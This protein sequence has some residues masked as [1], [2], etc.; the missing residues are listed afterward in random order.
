VNYIQKI[1]TILT[2][3]N[4]KDFSF[5]IFLSIIRTFI[6]VIGIGMLIPMFAFIT[7]NSDTKSKIF[8]YLS[9][10]EN[11]KDGQIILLFIFSFLFVY[12][13]KTMFVVFFN[14]Y[15][16]KFGEGL[17]VEISEKL[18]KKYLTKK[19]I[20]FVETNSANL[21]RNIASDTNGFAVGTVT[22]C[23]GIFSN[24]I[25][26]LGI[27]FL[28]IFYNFHSI[29]IIIAL[30]AICSLVANFNKK[31]FS[32]WAKIRHRESAKMIRKLNEGFGSIKEII[33]YKKSDY[34][35]DQ[36]KKPLINFS[37]AAVYKNAAA[38]I[39]APAI[40][41]AAVSIIFFF[42]VYLKFFTQIEFSEIITLFSILSFSAIK[43]LPNLT[44]ILKSFQTLKFNLPAVELIY[45][46]LI[47][48]KTNIIGNN[49]YI[50]DI[51]SIV[52]DK[53]NFR[54]PNTSLIALKN[55]NLQINSGDKIGIV[56]DTGSGKTTLINLIS[57]L[58]RPSS[59]NIL[60]NSK[61]IIDSKEYPL[62]VGYV[63]QSVY[64]SDDSILANISLSKKISKQQKI[65][66]K[67][68]LKILNLNNLNY[69]L[70]ERGSKLSGGQ[71]QRIGIARALY[72][73]PPLLIL[74]EA[75]NALDQKTEKKV[76]DFI[77]KEFNNKTVIFCTH[78]KKLL[79]Y[80]NKI[81][82]VKDAQ[83]SIIKN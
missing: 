9:F 79:K 63:S 80:C 78:K 73:E 72:R 51:S 17:Y 33:L 20:F 36:V 25:L 4:K 37:H 82:K 77:F 14:V 31:K 34:F 28:L 81:I 39:T 43:L 16:S 75:T 64:L 40:E 45:N 6:E 11:F 18:L 62:N 76:L 83:I 26:S 1:L 32:G 44:G 35:S 59:G 58:L 24:I 19:F 52:F 22:A 3:N 66:I 2:K 42:F 69:R 55:I 5:I 23:I 65:I 68:L 10:L 47:K 70:G 67:K 15:L 8:N 41:L 49:P 53:V 12:L 48:E 71:I 38:A 56:G 27:C 57:G 74:D 46:D 54:Y 29:F 50:S 60:I 7:S 61:K 21:I 30:L 13:I